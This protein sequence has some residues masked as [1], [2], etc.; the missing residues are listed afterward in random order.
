MLWAERSDTAGLGHRHDTPEAAARAY[1]EQQAQV[2]GLSP[3][4]LEAAY[5]HQVHDVG[6][7]GIIVFFR[8]RVAGLEVARTELKVLMT[9]DLE[10]VALT[11]NLHH[12]VDQVLKDARFRHPPSEAVLKALGDSHGLSLAGEVRQVGLTRPGQPLFEV[13]SGGALQHTGIALVTPA[14]VTPLYHPVA[15]QLVPAYAVDILSR[16]A[17]D[18]RLHGDAYV[19]HADTGEVLLR[20]DRTAS[21]AYTYRVWADAEGTPL[22]GPQVDFTP[23]PTGIP[24]GVEPG[25]TSPRQVTVEGRP[26]PGSGEVAPWLPP[27]ATFTSGNNVRAYADHFDPDGYTDGRDT[28]ALVTP[29][30]RDFPHVY[31][32]NAGPLSSSTQAAASVAQLFYT[33]NWLHDYFHDS[34]FDEAAGNAQ[35]VNQGPLGEAGDAL[36]AETQN[37]EREVARPRNRAVAYVPRDGLSPRLEFSVWAT[38]ETRSFNTSGGPYETGKAEFG[39]QDFNLLELPLVLAV[40]S[41]NPTADACEPLQND[42]VGAI[43]LADRGTCLY[44]LKAVNAQN[45]Q[46]AGLII[47]NHTPGEPPPEM[48]DVDATL[49]A[50]IPVLS[51]TYETGL[52]LKELL[53]RGTL[54]GTMSRATLP[55]RDASLDNTIVA[56]EW[57]HVM[58]RRLIDCTTP[59][60]RAMGEGWS[61]FL[62]LHLMVRE[63]DDAD[64]TYAIGGYAAQFLG[65]STYYGVRRSPYSRDLTKNGFRFRH[66]ANGVALPDQP[67]LRDNGLEN[68]QMHN[69]GEVWASLLFDAYQ[70]LLEETR[71]SAPRIA[72]FDEARRRMADYVVTSMKTAPMDVTFTQQRDALLMAAI[73]NDDPRDMQVLAHAFARRGAGTCAVSPPYDSEEFT[74]VVEDGRAHSN[75]RLESVEVKDGARSCDQDGLLD[76]S[77]QGIVEVVLWNHGPVASTDG[78]LR[79]SSADATL[80]FPEGTTFPIGRVEPF[81]STSV[82]I[83]IALASTR[84]GSRVGNYTLVLESAEA[85]EPRVEQPRSV[86]THYDLAPSHLDKVEGL[87]TPWRTEVLGGRPTQAWRVVDSPIHN[88]EKVWFAA[89]H[90]DFADTVLESP[91]L[92]IPSGTPFSLSFEHR[93]WFDFRRDA[94]T[95]AFE[96]WNGGVIEFLQAPGKTWTDVSSLIDVGYRGPLESGTGNPLG[97]SPAYAGQNKDWPGSE[98]V[99][100]DFGTKLSGNVKFR[101]R[102]GSAVVFEAHGWEIDNI[103]VQGTESPPFFARVEETTGPCL[104]RAFAGEDQ[105]VLG[106]APV[107][108]DGSLSSDV[109]LAPLAFS[110]RQLSGPP[111]AL[112][113]ANTKRPGFTAPTVAQVMELEFELTV[114]VADVTATDLVRI[115]ARPKATEEPDAGTPDAGPLPDAGEPDAGTDKSFGR[116]GMHSGCTSFGGGGAGLAWPLGLLGAL[117]LTARRRRRN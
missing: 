10:L 114:S 40:D 50:T 88:G 62:A 26:S 77:E 63:G 28:R 48:F 36:L 105:S 78:T 92:V 18:A 2:Y 90:Y 70:A 86:L 53:T 23:H 13:A 54:S 45:A 14:R 21:D 55:E 39:A 38:S 107:E 6:R 34:G 79:I 4:D 89:D 58:S 64:G 112:Q 113:G 3:A 57:G 16:R 87:R 97:G 91:T 81:K 109:G 95:G 100:L 25:F 32:T 76:A 94:R 15:G 74:E 42:V 103:T 82:A 108:L 98:K 43:V 115:T 111:V 29:G 106:G 84:V 102:L 85:C 51:V 73:S 20:E 75:L 68:S 37:Q 60:C 44:E 7:G 61:D 101:F 33:T 83:P 117:L 31:D 22:D 30:T 47:I 93:H 59:Q 69:A 52:A 11:G 8:Q 116:P 99:T 67:Y 80:S 9:R 17:G 46:A 41:G 71:G 49:T 19:I 96:Y 24:D 65:D 66:L 110:W 72:S 56:H 1:L 5:V 12:G 35:D 27:G 104:P